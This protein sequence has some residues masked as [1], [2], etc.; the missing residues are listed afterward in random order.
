MTIFIVATLGNLLK[1]LVDA[2]PRQRPGPAGAAGDHGSVLRA[3][4]GNKHAVE[5]GFANMDPLIPL[6]TK[7]VTLVEIGN[8]CK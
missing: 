1:S 2:M 7:M 3:T 5:C 4:R 8:R 6:P